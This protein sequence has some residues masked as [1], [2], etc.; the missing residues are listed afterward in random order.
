VRDL[1]TEQSAAARHERLL[2]RLLALTRVLVLCQAAST[3]GLDWAAARNPAAVTGV[4][5]LLALENAAIV[6][7]YARRG[8]CDSRSL[9]VLDVCLGMAAL[10]A[11]LALL[12]PTADPAVGNILYPYT[13]TTLSVIGFA[14]RRLWPSLTAAACTSAV[15]VL[16]TWWHFR[17]GLAPL[18]GNASTYWAWAVAGWFLADRFGALSTCLD[19]ARRAAAAQQ[20][21]LAAERERSRH[22]RELHAVRMAAA[23]RELEQEREQARLS[24]ALHDHVLQTLEFMGKEGWI[25]DPVIRD[26]VA[27]EAAW[28]RQL[29]RGRLDRGAGA[30]AAALDGAVQQQTRAGMRIELNTAGL[31][32][33][34]LPAEAVEAL[35]GAVTELLTNVRKHAG[36]THAVVRAVSSPGMV[37]VTV[38]DHGRGF[39]PIK[40]TDGVG[41]RE[42]VRARVQEAGGHVVVTS[43]PGAGTHVEITV[44]VTEPGMSRES[45]TCPQQ[46]APTRMPM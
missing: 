26:H 4:L 16:A 1:L 2:V 36:T 35:A 42:S 30:L 8:A 14:Y 23:V 20:A 39:D 29:V 46:Q 31:G 12:K 27:A 18:L 19:E 5:V 15:Y 28:L 21:E 41:L 38:L 3:L 25:S 37:T 10:I 45:G 6:S 32:A 33:A 34:A 22:A 17:S 43:E 11:V 44:P 24:R 7:F 13:V 9:A 40:A